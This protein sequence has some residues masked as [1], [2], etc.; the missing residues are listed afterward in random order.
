MIKKAGLVPEIKNEKCLNCGAGKISLNPIPG[1]LV[2]YRCSGCGSIHR[3]KGVPLQE[4]ASNGY[5]N[6]CTGHYVKWV[7]TLKVDQK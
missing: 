1:S 3:F 5:E 2:A 6:S 4:G 7:M